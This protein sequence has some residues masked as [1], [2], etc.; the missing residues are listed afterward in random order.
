M[1]MDRLLRVK[2]QMRLS[3]KIAGTETEQLIVELEAEDEDQTRRE[4][5]EKD[6]RIIERRGEMPPGAIYR[7]DR[8]HLLAFPGLL[9]PLNLG[10]DPV[11]QSLRSRITKSFPD[12]FVEWYRALPEHIDV[13][14]DD[15]LRTLL[16][17]PV[18]ASV[19]FES[20]RARSIGST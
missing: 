18:K 14:I 10:R 13:T 7:Y 3:Q 16:A 4:V 17:D 11:R 20:C 2:L 19:T 6:G 9:A 1:V 8:T 12:R 15:H 5:M